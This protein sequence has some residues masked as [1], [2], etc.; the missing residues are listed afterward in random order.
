MHAAGWV[1]LREQASCSCVHLGFAW[2]VLG[3]AMRMP[4]LRYVTG[5]LLDCRRTV[6]QDMRALLPCVRHTPT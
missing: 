3:V 2:G 6:P 4:R 1:M 5:R